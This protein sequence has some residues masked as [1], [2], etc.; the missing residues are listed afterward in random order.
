MKIKNHVLSAVIVAV[1]IYL[2]FYYE[3]ISLLG[4]IVG[5]ILPDILE[6]PSSIHHRKFFH[7]RKLLKVIPILALLAF[8]ASLHSEQ[9]FWLFFIFLGYEIHL[10]EDLIFH[11]LPR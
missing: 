11:G 2:I 7:S 3:K 9:F 5:V 6:P 10:L 1:A 8:L 4:I